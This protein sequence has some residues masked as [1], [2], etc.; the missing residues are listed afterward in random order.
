MKGETAL[1]QAKTPSEPASRTTRD[2]LPLDLSFLD[3]AFSYATRRGEGKQRRARQRKRLVCLRGPIF[4]FDVFEARLRH[5]QKFRQKQFAG[6]APIATNGLRGKAQ[7]ETQNERQE[8]R[9]NLPW[10]RGEESL[11]QL[12]LLSRG[13]FL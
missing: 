2:D 4:P 6:R 9:T 1:K 7:T 12:S 5:I 10:V 8:G 11:L 3:L 13:N